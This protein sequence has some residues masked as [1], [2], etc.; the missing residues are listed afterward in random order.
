MAWSPFCWTWTWNWFSFFYL[1]WL[2]WSELKIEIQSA[3]RM[4]NRIELAIHLLRLLLIGSANKFMQGGTTYSRNWKGW[5]EHLSDTPHEVE[6]NSTKKGHGVVSLKSSM[7]NHQNLAAFSMLCNCRGETRMTK[8]FVECAQS[9]W[10]GY[11]LANM[12]S[13][14]QCWLFG[15]LYHDTIEQD[16]PCRIPACREVYVYVLSIFLER[17]DKIL[18]LSFKEFI[19]FTAFE[20]PLWLLTFIFSLKTVG[21]DW[22]CCI[23]KVVSPSE[24]M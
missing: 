21:V 8:V 1:F 2:I 5:S 24:S 12:I 11:R 22:A 18:L 15:S 7:V 23:H 14:F 17:Y 10:R 4:F 3:T 19:I 6:W 20:I 16:R 9:C 13:R